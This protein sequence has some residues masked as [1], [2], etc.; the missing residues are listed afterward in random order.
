MSPEELLDACR[1]KAVR[2]VRFLYCD[3]GGVVRGK[4][5][6]VERLAERIRTGI[7]LTVAMQAMNS[8]DQLQPVE[9]MGP[10]GEIR[11]VPDPETFTVLPYAPHT[12]AMLVDHVRLDGEPYEAGP[13]TFLKRMA[14]RLAERGM[15]LSCAVENEWSLATQRE[16]RHV[17]LDESLCFSTVGMGASAEVVDATVA[18]LG[19]QGIQV[20]QYYAEL[21]H[22]QQELSV[23]PR[24]AVRAAD[25]QVLVRETIRGVAARSGLV[26][27]LAPKPWPDQ[28]GNGAH[29]HLSVWDLD[30]E[31]NLF[32]DPAGR[33]GLSR[34]AERFVA[35][36]LAHLPGLLALT[37]PSVNSYQRLLPQNW[38][39]AFVCWGPDNREAT[40]RV[41]STYWGMERATTN[42]E[43]KPTD[44]SCNPYL[45]FGGLIAAGL[46]GIERKLEPPEPLSVD[47][48]TLSDDER[49]AAGAYRYPT[50]LEASLGSLERD[51]VLVEALGEPLARSY[52]AVRRSEWEAYSAMTEDARFRGH[53]LKY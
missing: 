51:R 34:T 9:G 24:P 39:S 6:H 45:A 43:F 32:H 15:V 53:F 7:G 28:A 35:G 31:R 1:T 11:L 44:A 40:V 8:L 27:S 3:N 50:T 37:A 33:F 46:D 17:P 48:G 25:T 21:G 19:E 29:I 36:V 49:T 52:L 30:G 41:P 23:T 14:A 18:A 16:G 47:P 4:A 26:A 13:R 2:L 22:G 42:L 38:S 20:E 5:T 10:V 12:A